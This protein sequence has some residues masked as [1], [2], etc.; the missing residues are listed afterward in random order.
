MRGLL[1]LFPRGALE[2]TTIFP[3]AE[4]PREN[5]SDLQSTEGQ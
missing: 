3:R 5:S 4:G 2:T 1:K